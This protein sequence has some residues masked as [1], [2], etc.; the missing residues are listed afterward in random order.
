M[1]IC[2]MHQF[3]NSVVIDTGMLCHINRIRLLTNFAKTFLKAFFFYRQA[4]GLRFILLSSMTA[5]NFKAGLIGH[6]FDFVYG[7]IRPAG[8]VIVI[9]HPQF[10]ESDN[11]MEKSNLALITQPRQSF[12]QAL[13]R[14]HYQRQKVPVHQFLAST[15]LQSQVRSHLFLHVRTGRLL[16]HG[17]SKRPLLF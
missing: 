11:L 14:T 1:R 12:H 5:Y 15:P 2:N 4:D 6:L 9:S 16:R 8:H 13:L 7:R 17:H 10:F 3:G